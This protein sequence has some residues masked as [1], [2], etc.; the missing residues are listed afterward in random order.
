MKAYRSMRVESL[1]QLKL[2]GN[3]AESGSPNPDNLL[4]V[5][6][7]GSLLGPGEVALIQ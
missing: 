2:R 4:A 1:G 5:E 3:P 6:Q 7:Y